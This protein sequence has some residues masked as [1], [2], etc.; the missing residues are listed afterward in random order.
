[1]LSH[2][3]SK[4][5]IRHFVSRFHLYREATKFL[6]LDVPVEFAL[7]FTRTKDQQRVCASSA[8]QHFS[9]DFPPL[10]QELSL[11]PIFRDEIIGGVLVLR[12]R[13]ARRPTSR[14]YA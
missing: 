1:M 13:C 7:G 11:A 8:S 14:L 3:G 4:L 12:A 9:I 2:F 10:V 6:R 5:A